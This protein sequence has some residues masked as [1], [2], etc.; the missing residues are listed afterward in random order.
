MKLLHKL[1]GSDAGAINEV[2]VDRN[3]E[4]CLSVGNDRL[5]RLWS[6]KRGACIKAYVGHGRPLHTADI[7]P[8]NDRLCSAGE[9]SAI[10][11]WDVSTAKAIR[12]IRG[13]I[14]RVNCVRFHPKGQLILS[15]GYDTK[16]HIWDCRSNMR[17]PVQ[18]L[19]DAQDSVTT[20]CQGDGTIWTT[21][22]DGKIRLYD[23]R[24]GQL[25]E[26]FL[27]S[28]VTNFNIS[29]DH[30]CYL[31]SSLDN[32]HRLFDV[33][34]GELLNS[35]TG[36]KSKDFRVGLTF[37]HDESQVISGSE[38]GQIY[39]WDLLGGNLVSSID[40]HSSLVTSVAAGTEGR[41]IVSASHDGDIHVWGATS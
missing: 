10:I 15:G 41:L 35:F 14:G 6:L 12:R 1:V 8:E 17:D 22:V 9:D 4:Y 34:S 36:H 26:D 7:A 21:S 18:S 27:G 31:A 3:S 30:Q 25:V 39:I 29:R 11:L 5:L 24:N 37:S 40:A 19:V 33:A 20:L 13:H 32:T 38:D 2:R 16:V 28:A 23:V